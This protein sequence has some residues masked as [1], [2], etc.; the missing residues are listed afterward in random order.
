MFYRVCLSIIL[1]L[2]NCIS[3]I[4]I[5][6]EVSGEFI[7]HHIK[8]DAGLPHQQVESMAFDHDG[9]LW[10]GT[11][12]GLAKYDGYSFVVYYNNPKEESSIPH[13]FIR[14]IFVDSDNNVWIGTDREICRYRRETDDFQR[15]DVKGE[16]ITRICAT[17]DG[18]IV[19]TGMK[20]FKKGKEEESFSQVPRQLESYVVGLDIAP[21]GKIY[22]STNHS[23]SYFSPDMN[24]ET[25]LDNS[26]FSEFLSGFD[27]IAPLF[28][29]QKGTLWIGR[30][31][32][33]VMKVNLLT[34][35]KI[36]YD[37]NLLTDGTVRTITEDSK[38]NIWLGTEKGITIINPDSD[39]IRLI[40][41]RFGDSS[42]LSDNAI[43][44][45]LPDK[46]DNIWVGTYFGGINLM[47]RN[48]LQFNWLLPESDKPSFNGKVIR[49][50]VETEK[51]IIWAATEDGGVNI[52]DTNKNVINQ[53]KEMPE[54]GTNVHALYY[55]EASED[56]WIGT[57]RNGLF[58]YN[59][60][61][62]QKKHYTAFNSGLKSNAIFAISR[63]K[64][65]K[66]RLWIATT[67]GL[68]Y[69][70]P[71]ND[72]IKPVNNPALDIDFIYCLHPDKR[73]NLWV[74]SVNRGL[75]RIDGKSGEI[76]G[77]NSESNSN[78]WTLK[79]NYITTVFEDK[80]NRVFIGT[81]NGGIQILDG[82]TL[83]FMPFEISDK[84]WG[85]ICA[86][87]Q[88]KDFNIWI[89]TS[90]GLHKIKP[91]DFSE[92]SFNTSDGL[93]ENQFN[94]SSILLASNNLLYCGTVNGLVVFEPHITKQ[95]EKSLGVHLWGIALNNERMS[96]G[97]PGSPLKS[98]L[99]VT[100]NLS[101][102]YAESRIF[103]IDYGVIDPI[104][105]DNINYQIFVE[106]LD[107]EWRDVGSQRSF[108]AMELP[109]GKYKFKVRAA[110]EGNDWNLSPITSLDLN[111]KPPFYLSS[112]AWVVYFIL[113]I[114]I[115][116]LIY[117]LI[118]WR[119][120]ER[121]QK[122][123]NQI[124]L[125][126]NDELN[127]EKMEFFTNISHELKT[128]LSL[129]LAPLKQLSSEQSMTE[130]SRE[131]LSTAIANTTKMVDLINELVT[132][133]RVESGNF[134]LYLQK[135]NPLPLIETMVGY[136]RGP[137]SDKKISINITTQDNGEDVWFSTIYLER[138][139][140][141]LLSNAIKYT[142]ENGNIDIRA[143]I[144]EGENNNVFLKLEVKD[145]GIG[146]EESELQNIF[147]KYYQT[148]RGYNNSYSGWGIG[149]ATVKKLVEIHKGEIQVTSKIGMGSTFIVKLN[150]TQDVFDKSA[151]ISKEDSNSISPQPS[152]ISNPLAYSSQNLSL[153]SNGA[154]RHEISILI[155]EDNPELLQF[156]SK[157]FSSLYNVYTATNGLD[158]LKVTEEHNI[159]IIVSD[160]MMPEMDGIEL[161]DKLKNNLATSH[162]PVIL[163]TAKSDEKSTLSGFKSGAEAYIAKP[164]DPQLLI[165]RV[166][167]ILRAR[168]VTINSLHKDKSDNIQTDDEIEENLPPLNKFDSEF[169]SKI[170]DFVEKNIDNS[171]LSVTDITREL[172][173]SRSLLHIKM[174]N[175]FN[176]SMS[177]YIKTCRMNKAKEYL[178]QGFN[179]SETAYK[180]G[181][182]DPNYFTKVFKATF[183]ITPRE[184]LSNQ[185]L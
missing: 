146:I 95:T 134:Q 75:F 115:I 80:D 173:I 180:T 61:N 32:K 48:S 179:V 135:G 110:E 120:K 116:Y 8:S 29:D 24:S 102:D 142:N 33:G 84:N 9:L 183:G 118:M 184:Y 161:C 81:N 36:I 159:D 105:I 21:D 106:G 34:G 97:A 157:E 168:K 177:D 66:N 92:I 23:I 59:L 69:Y 145:T 63:Q 124:E 176:T 119:M 73:G 136:F 133:N 4:S 128:P 108:T 122:R 164:F 175:F 90:N 67:I 104:G 139:L 77:W 11:R 82:N 121:H 41:Q 107:N 16:P 51:G 6:G 155:V 47:K 74:G 10:V 185:T 57:F 53:F 27:A 91:D 87:A 112:M 85:T 40:R 147:K 15:Y 20:V 54:I 12:N 171:D 123:L 137:A 167:N 117:K 141:N 62:H 58:R 42:S 111:I 93:P 1:V 49:G 130:D 55:D 43:Y 46:W 52:Y 79:D 154:D 70:E 148:K 99:D 89:T 26:I 68:M 50:L 35:E 126:K 31:G 45:I 131:R 149:L 114:S 28:F 151:Y 144:V 163:L 169:V 18:T 96:P 83:Q 88:D 174:K 25:I 71:E 162:I 125:E 170:S 65:E 109:Y 138:I 19:C 44:C 22:M 39:E 86:V 37:A 153:N 13:N 14:K 94:F 127:R 72:C 150:V 78:D 2:I 140:S 172:G 182:S 178:H 158:A 30:D 113:A 7:F 56:L 166:Q 5:K 98:S 132:F 165:L 129:I 60:K 76:R 156:L 17:S 152:F 100:S 143:S 64:D 101:L 181:F 160:V 3:S 103:S 38:G